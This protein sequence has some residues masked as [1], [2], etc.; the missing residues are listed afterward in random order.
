M[1]GGEEVAQTGGEGEAEG[2]AKREEA[3]GKIDGEAEDLG[4]ECSGVGVGENMPGPGLE[5]STVLL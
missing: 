5:V 3:G 4:I 2:E 1:E